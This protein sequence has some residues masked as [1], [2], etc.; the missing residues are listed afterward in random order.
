MLKMNDTNKDIFIFVKA[1]TDI[2]KSRMLQQ[3]DL[4]NTIVVVSKH[5]LG[6]RR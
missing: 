1:T 6:L 2:G 3:V 4:K 5:R